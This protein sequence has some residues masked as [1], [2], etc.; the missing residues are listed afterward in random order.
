VAHCASKIRSCGT[1]LVTFQ[2]KAFAGLGFSFFSFFIREDPFVVSWK[3]GERDMRGREQLSHMSSLTRL[4]RMCREPEWP[5][6]LLRLVLNVV[7]LSCRTQFILYSTKPFELY[8][9]FA[10][11]LY[12]LSGKVKWIGTTMV[13][14]T[15]RTKSCLTCAKL[16]ASIVIMYTQAYQRLFVWWA[17]HLSWVYRFIN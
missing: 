10:R 5:H 1:D 9:T 3:L 12:Q 6:G 16:N 11:R 14:Q 15:C 7:L 17:A 13:W 2:M 4:L 8:S